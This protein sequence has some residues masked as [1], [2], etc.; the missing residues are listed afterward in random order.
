[1][2]NSRQEHDPATSERRWFTTTH[3]SVVLNAVDTASPG[4]QEALEKLCQTYWYPLYAY[5]RQQGH[6]AEDAQDLT[7]EFFARF[8]EK[9]HVRRAD[10]GRGRFR[11]F[12]LTSLKHFL[13]S[14]WRRHGAQKRGGTIPV[15]AL[16]ALTAEERFRLEPAHELTPDKIF[17]RSWAWTVLEQVR[18]QLRADYTGAGGPQRLE[19]LEKFLFGERGE[20]TYAEAARH[21]GLAEGTVKADVHQLKGRFRALLREAV[22]HTVS[23]PEEINDELDHLK[24]A[25]AT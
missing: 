4:A 16:E 9:K 5:V 13:I 15:I 21:L 3:W 24:T 23:R 17:E 1:M 22:A 6:N 20:L 7:Q 18:A 19:C 10:R 8:L 14:E 2:S 11:S 12:L 25:L